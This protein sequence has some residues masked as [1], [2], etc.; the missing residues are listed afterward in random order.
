MPYN[1]PLSGKDKFVN[2]VYSLVYE[3]NYLNIKTESLKMQIYRMYKFSD[4]VIRLLKIEITLQSK[5]PQIKTLPSSSESPPYF[6][7][8]KTLPSFYSLSAA[9]IRGLP[10]SRSSFC[11][12]YVF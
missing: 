12:M 2:N 4:E 7:L 11:S 3:C 5:N 9:E 6:S 1:C 8:R 10:S